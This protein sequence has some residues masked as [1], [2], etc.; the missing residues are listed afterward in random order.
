MYKMLSEEF[1]VNGIENLD[2]FMSN[3]FIL[4]TDDINLRIVRLAESYISGLENDEEYVK[5]L[6]DILESKSDELYKVLDKLDSLNWAMNTLPAGLFFHVDDILRNSSSVAKST[7]SVIDLKC[8]TFVSKTGRFL[9][10]EN[11]LNYLDKD[12][13]YFIYKLHDLSIYK[14]ESYFNPENSKEANDMIWI[15]YYV[16]DKKVVF[17]KSN[18]IILI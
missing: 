17:P 8:S 10:Y 16:T 7:Q 9:S 12:R 1:P 6:S 3:Q 4:K 13:F 11:F 5:I 2:Y 18:E 15:R 14:N